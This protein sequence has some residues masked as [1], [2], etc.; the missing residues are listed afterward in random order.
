VEFAVNALLAK[1]ERP[2]IEVMDELFTELL[3]AARDCGVPLRT[4]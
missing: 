1:G 2:S 4:A 3:V